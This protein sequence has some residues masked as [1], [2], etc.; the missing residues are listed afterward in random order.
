M[1]DF[2]LIKAFIALKNNHQR[3][4]KKEILIKNADHF[5]KYFYKKKI[6]E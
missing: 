2:L 5:Y 1:V 3:K 4:K 6:I